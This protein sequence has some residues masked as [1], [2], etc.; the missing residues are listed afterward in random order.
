MMWLKILSGALVLLVTSGTCVNGPD[1]PQL[2][3]QRSPDASERLFKQLL[4]EFES[5]DKDAVV[6]TPTRDELRHVESLFARSMD[7]DLDVQALRREW[8]ELGYRLVSLEQQRAW[9]AVE[10]PDHQRGRG[11]Y[12][13]RIGASRPLVV[14]APH[15]WYDLRTGRLAARWFAEQ[16]IMAACWNSVHRRNLDLP[17]VTPH[18]FNAFT[19]A[20][21]DR[22]P[23]VTVLQ[24]HGFAKSRKGV[25]KSVQMIVSDGSRY[26]GQTA[27]RAARELKS[28]FGEDRVALFPLEVQVLGGTTNVQGQLLRSQGCTRFVHLEMGSEIRK[29]LAKSAGER[30][31]LY[32]CLDPD[33]ANR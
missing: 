27:R 20:A 24:L 25:P 3:V 32:R 13:W 29:T 15:R 6:A 7:P 23:D 2:L 10:Q 33:R 4:R 9:L 31:K 18:Y 22:T 11:I 26:P 1:E 21:L 30:G 28:S 14:Q 19:R 12:A 17:D 5:V 16:E 8:N